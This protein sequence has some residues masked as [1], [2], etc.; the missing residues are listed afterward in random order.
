MRSNSS[1]NIWGK[2]GFTVVSKLV[3]DDGKVLAET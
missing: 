1:L 2:C 3:Q